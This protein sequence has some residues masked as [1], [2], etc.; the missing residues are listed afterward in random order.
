M[1]SND[2]IDEDNEDIAATII[3]CVIESVIK[4]LFKLF[5]EQKSNCHTSKGNENHIFVCLFR[6]LLSINAYTHTHTKTQKERE[7]WQ[8]GQA[9]RQTVNQ[10][11]ANFVQQL[12]VNLKEDKTAQ[13][14]TYYT[15]RHK[16][17]HKHTN[18]YINM[19]K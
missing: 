5:Q 4:F 9:N 13:R 1:N 15:H 2:H 14:T 10:Q 12:D 7:K 16:Y 19:Y 8:E 18:T 11:F 6:G 17:K 3:K